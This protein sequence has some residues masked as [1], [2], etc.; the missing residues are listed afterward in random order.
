MYRESILANVALRDGQWERAAEILAH[1]ARKVPSGLRDKRVDRAWRNVQREL[2][3]V[4]LRRAISSWKIGKIDLAVAEAASAE[5]SDEAYV[6]SAAIILLAAAELKRG[7]HDAAQAR[8][9]ALAGHDPRFAAAVAALQR[10]ATTG[11]D[12]TTAQNALEAAFARLD[13]SVDF[14]TR[15]LAALAAGASHAGDAATTAG[16]QAAPVTASSGR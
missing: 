4:Q 1:S 6:R 9:Q 15:P 12:S 16:A 11:S 3:S 13:R 14:V 10:S 5:H 7:H 8:L 2:W